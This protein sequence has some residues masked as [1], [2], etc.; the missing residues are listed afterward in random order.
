MDIYCKVHNKIHIATD[1]ESD[2]CQRHGHCLHPLQCT[3][4]WICPCFDKKSN[5]CNV[6]NKRHLLS[7][8]KPDLCERHGHCL[9][10]KG[11]TLSAICQC[12]KNNK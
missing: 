3:L 11:C 4:Y 5:Y 1:V 12:F 2:L 6:H 8:V 9:H 7:D 10:C